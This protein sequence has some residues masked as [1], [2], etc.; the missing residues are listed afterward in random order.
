MDNLYDVIVVGYGGAGAVSAITAHDK[1]ASVLILEKMPGGGGNTRLSGGSFTVPTSKDF[2]SYL[3]KLCFGTTER[4][5]LDVYTENAMKIED[6]IKNLGGES[7]RLPARSLVVSY[8]QMNTR[9]AFS[10][11]T[12]AQS[13]VKCSIKGEEQGESKGGRNLWNFLSGCVERRAIKVMTNAAVQEL[14]RNK[15]GEVNGVIAEIEGKKVPI[16][17]RRAVILACGGFENNP[18]LQHEYLPVK[19]APFVGNPGNTGDGIAMA[20]KAGAALWHM[21]AL[22]SGIGLKV[23]GYEV[24]F[25]I[26]FYGPQFI[27]V[28]KYGKRYF[29]EARGVE[30]H[31]FWR[32]FSYFDANRLEYP[33]MP[34]YAIFGEEVR[35]KGPIIMPGT[36]G[37]NRDIYQWSE[38]NSKEIDKGWIVKTKTVRELANRLSLDTSTLED[39]IA[40][41]NEYCRKGQ[42]PDFGRPKQDLLPI[43]TPYYAIEIWPAIANTQGGPRRDKESRVLDPYGK[44]IPGL[45]AAG[46]LGSIWGF[47]YPGGCNNSEC[48]VFGQIAGRNAAQCPE[49]EP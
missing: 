34:S 44:P 26:A 2:T 19:E 16:R 49:V 5:I 28:D 20:Q 25:F 24:A 30:P 41:Y 8:P 1:G 39:T 12:G 47:I 22:V 38:D 32:P 29:D 14:V 11:I 7:R 42:D 27:I 6:W 31:E 4:E 33:R 17:A 21:A 48:L 36:T 23:S 3:D 40:K 9:T 10:Q 43:E 18:G 45:Y 46:E 13:M 15:K 35:R 37:W